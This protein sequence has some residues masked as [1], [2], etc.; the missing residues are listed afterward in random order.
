MIDLPVKYVLAWFPM[1]VVALLI[2]AARD[3]TWGRSLN[4][5]AARRVTAGVAGAAFGLYAVG[6]VALLPFA[7]PRQA[8][9]TGGAW[10]LITAL[11]DGMLRLLT[12]DEPAPAAAPDDLF[13]EPA[14]RRSWS[15]LVLLAWIGVVPWLVD[16]WMRRR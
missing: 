16:A 2:G 8:L 15:N 3:R 5:T 14:P 9:W 10:M 11:L 13:T 6:I 4:P 7:T 12:P 1:V